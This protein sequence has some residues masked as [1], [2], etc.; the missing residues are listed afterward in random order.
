MNYPENIEQKLGF[1]AVR[2]HVAAL[3]DNNLGKEKCRTMAFTTNYNLIRTLIGQVN[4]Y[5]TILNRGEAMPNGA[6]FDLRE[7][8]ERT[9]VAGTYLTESELLNLGKT[10][11]SAIEIHDFFTDERRRAYPELWRLAESLS[12]FP[13]VV[14]TIDRTLDRFG[15]VKDS[16]SATLRELRSSLASTTNSINGLLS[17]VLSRYKNEGIL[18]ADATPAMRDG[19]LVLPVSA[20]NKRR[21]AGIVHDESS[22]GKTFF[23]E[24][25]EIVE[26][27]NKIRELESDI[28][29]EIVRI[30][31]EITD[32]IRPALPEL[33]AFYRIIGVFDFVRAKALFADQIGAEM[34]HIARRPEIEWYGAKHPVLLLALNK[35][36][37]PTVPL[38]IHLAGDNRI[39]LISGPNAGGKSVC[40]KTVGIVQYMLQCGL[41]PPVYGNSHFGIFDSIFIE[42]GDEQSIENELS[43]YSSH[44]SNMKL[45]MQR[46]N[47]QTLVL[48]DEF[49][50]GTEPQI[51]GALA[52]AVLRKLNDLGVYGV[53]TTH[54]Q[55]LKNF[56]NSTP[57][58]V[59]GAMLYDRQKMQP[60]FQLSIGTPGSSFAIEI[61]KKIGIPAEILSYAEEIVGS[62]YINLDKYLMDIARDRK[63]WEAKRDEI[64]R[65]RKR[66]DAVVERYESD[67]EKLVEERR[68]II[69]EAKSEAKEI[70]STSNASIENAIHEIKRAQAEKEQTK[71]IRRQIDELKQRLAEGETDDET[72]RELKARLRHKKK[73]PNKPVEKPAEVLSVGDNVT[74]DGSNSVG[75]I[76]AID[77][78]N[79]TV[80]IGNFLSTVKLD[81]LK[82]T[83]RKETA[84][85]T[86]K[87]AVAA[88]V[89]DE[90]RNRQLNFKQEID[91]RG[92]R[93]DEAIQAVSYFIDDAV[94]FG[95]GEVRILHGTGFGILRQRIREYLNATP[96]VRSYR[97][98]HIQF[99]GA[100]I[101]VV[102]LR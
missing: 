48:I 14:A 51:G 49:G 12:L 85:A 60:L 94:Q 92:M 28:R 54:Y 71:L 31:T 25:S 45:F 87:S 82:K 26:K 74:I 80:A 9:R 5:K 59:N 58:I 100:G 95:I 17:R 93:A 10:L 23:I 43:T 33:A 102:T 20:M 96:D 61:A 34:P 81:K 97:D 55:N 101:T 76:T 8:L 56:A 11:R 36:G 72:I 21:V 65:E 38:N 75:R 70:V 53:I 83:I 19:R 29:R 73:Q 47:D 79:A 18:D 67:I 40:L 90:A 4:E 64:R 98:E 1:T 27:N 50:G 46:G 42:I 78:N 30:L 89:S 35:A 41:L 37:K 63:Y 2:A 16:A 52:Q 22:T 32:S 57:G 68:R 66:L 86:S 7:E 77:R 39:L 44:L 91:V 88:S 13:D 69:H 15:E 6:V 84:T 3:C 24:P 62:E 99:G